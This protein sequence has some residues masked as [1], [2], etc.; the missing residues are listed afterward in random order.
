[1]MSFI[2]EKALV[3]KYAIAPEVAFNYY[4]E[5]GFVDIA[6]LKYDFDSTTDRLS[7]WEIKTEL[8]DIGETLRQINK[9]REYLIKAVDKIGTLSIRKERTQIISY[10]VVTE[11]CAQTLKDNSQ[12]FAHPELYVYGVFKDCKGLVLLISPGGQVQSWLDTLCIAS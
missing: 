10:L 5:R 8:V 9:A 12:L 6:C 2:K 7:L 1:M 4:G 11:N 3:A